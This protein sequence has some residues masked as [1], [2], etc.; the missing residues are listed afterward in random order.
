[1][2]NSIHKAPCW[3]KKKKFSVWTITAMAGWARTA[4]LGAAFLI[5]MAPVVRAS[6][7]PDSFF[8]SRGALVW[9]CGACLAIVAVL[10]IAL[11]RCASKRRRAERALRE[12]RACF[13]EQ[14]GHRSRAPGRNEKLLQTVIKVT[15]DAM[16]AIDEKGLIT[17]FNPAAENMFGRTEEEMMGRP[18]DCLMPEMHRD[19]HRRNIKSYFETGRPNRAV[20]HIVELPAMR[21]DG[22][23]FSMNV[24]LSVGKIDREKFVIA[25]A[26]DIT[27][28]KQAEEILRLEM[29]QREQAENQLKVLVDDLERTN[30][31][32][33]DFA[34]IVSHDLKA[35]LRGVIS[36]ANWLREDCAGMLDD[37]GRRYI[38]K[39]IS[40]TRRMHD[41]IDGILQYSR[42]GR[43]SVKAE[44]VSSRVMVKEIL[45]SIEPPESIS[46]VIQDP[47]PTIVYDKMQLKQ[48]F[49]NLIGNAIEHLGK[50]RGRVCISCTDRDDA[51]EF[52]V[53]DN[54]VGI[55]EGHFEK[56]F[57]IFQSLNPQAESTG[58]GLS[59]VKKIAERN[60]GS[61]RVES[62]VGEGSA[63]YFTAPK[64]K[65]APKNR[66]KGSGAVL[67]IDD[68]QGFTDVAVTMLKREGREALC[69]VDG[70]EARQILE[71][72]EHA[73]DI[74]LMDMY[75]P[76]ESPIERYDMLK[77]MRPGMKII[78]CTGGGLTET[79]E[80]LK[81]KGVD[82]VL[83]KPFKGEELKEVLA[84]TEGEGK[85]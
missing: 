38:Q 70:N 34:Y 68:S 21:R 58:V 79:V 83:M 19:A 41:L 37:S 42:A 48:L 32:L 43:A 76:N 72:Y 20:G 33:Q 5:S 8:A 26:R 61:I 84:L 24:S 53:K 17:L 29:T 39:L 85:K 50:P 23:R 73:I 9:V 80:R 31:E 64:K 27:D 45:D 10:I 18:L 60:G 30:K 47:L 52:C 36:L 59:L 35:P 44:P 74:A 2:N 12:L 71:T 13:E 66:R 1:M 75:I 63:F 62:T 22:E 40:R 69:A 56:I 6:N 46:V 55:E 77:A 3:I 28:R 57:Q 11:I 16:I 4:A 7:Q 67:I 65:S 49:Q 81:K 25:V 15:R 54:G 51:W 82:G 14:A 78:V